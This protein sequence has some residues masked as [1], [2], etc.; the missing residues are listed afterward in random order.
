MGGLKPAFRSKTH[1]ER[2]HSG[3]ESSAERGEQCAGS[4]FRRAG[5][6]EVDS[7]VGG[8]RRSKSSLDERFDG[9][10]RSANMDL[11][12]TM[13]APE[14][15]LFTTE[16]LKTSQAHQKVRTRTR[17][18][19]PVVFFGIVLFKAYKDGFSPYFAG[20]MAMFSVAWFFLYPKRYDSLV[21]KQ[22]E[23]IIKDE[24]YANSFG[25]YHLTLGDEGLESVSPVGQ[26]SYPWSSVVSTEI[27]MGHLL[28]FLRGGQGYAISNQQVGEEN[29]ESARRL[30][31]ERMT[32]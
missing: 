3:S 1:L 25:E 15:L 30:I 28:I 23:K 27:S 17:F 16:F 26:S 12:F 4:E 13:G 31:Q 32:V 14:C 11:K 29:A 9:L 7:V 6:Y 8:C 19:G 24:S 21:K 20:F 5:V 2:C 22:A 18:I 10:S